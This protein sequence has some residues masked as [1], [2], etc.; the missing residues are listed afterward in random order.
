MRLNFLFCFLAASTWALADPV[1]M[2]HGEKLTYR[3]SW[4][5]FGK[6]AELEVSATEITDEGPTLTRVTS[7]TK[8]KGLI[9]AIY[10]FNGRADSYYDQTTGRLLSATATTKSRSKETNAS[11]EL[12]Y[13]TGEANYVDHLRE[14]R[15]LTVEVPRNDPADFITTLVL[16][17]HWDIEVGD[18]RE[19]SVLFDDEFYDLVITAE[20]EEEIRTRWGP[21]RALVLVPRMEENPQGMFKRGGEVR[22]WVSLDEDRLPLQFEVQISVGTAMAILTDYQRPVETDSAAAALTASAGL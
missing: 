7:L 1:A 5:L 2:T 21:K 22:V 11:I 8:T 4:G 9:R 14:N 6:A 19:V 13:D 18:R 20:R 10:P 16:S 3:L 12:D 15:S 17:R